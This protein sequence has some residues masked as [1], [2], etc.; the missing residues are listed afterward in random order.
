MNVI[1]VS[2]DRER[3]EKKRSGHTACDSK[4]CPEIVMGRLRIERAVEVVLF[5]PRQLDRV[6]ERR[7][8]EPNR[9]ETDDGPNFAVSLE[10]RSA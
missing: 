8:E 5:D 10:N 9:G 4:A 7:G 6:K 1:S 2:R 3:P